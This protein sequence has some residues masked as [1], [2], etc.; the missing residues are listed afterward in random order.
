MDKRDGSGS[1]FDILFNLR[2]NAGNIL[3]EDETF[4]R[5]EPRR[6]SFRAPE[7]NFP[8]RQLR[9][10][11]H[12]RPVKFYTRTRRRNRGINIISIGLIFEGRI[13]RWKWASRNKGWERGNE[14]KNSKCVDADRA[15]EDADMPN[16]IHLHYRLIN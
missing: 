11:A 16:V 3:R 7:V 1:H 13:Q 8:R 15:H 10:S 14:K 12:V 5:Y 6:P 2:S 9:H 4:W